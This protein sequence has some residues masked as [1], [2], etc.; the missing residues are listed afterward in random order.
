[1]CIR[2]RDVTEV[3]ISGEHLMKHQNAQGVSDYWI[4]FGIPAKEGNTYYAGYGAVPEE[5]G[6]PVDSI[7]DRTYEENGKTYNTVYFGLKAVSYTHLDVYKRQEIHQYFI[8]S[9]CVLQAFY[10]VFS[11]FV[12]MPKDGGRGSQLSCRTPFPYSLSLIHI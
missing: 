7:A 4:G 9:A 6:A 12:Q 3:T 10:A 8:Q 5:L 11:R 1:M 2:D